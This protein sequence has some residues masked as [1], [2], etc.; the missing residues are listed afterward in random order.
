ML[1][2][3]DSFPA[4]FLVCRAV[5]GVAVGTFS[6]LVPLLRINLCTSFSPGNLARRNCRNDRDNSADLCIYD[7]IYHVDNIRPDGGRSARPAALRVYDEY[8][9][10]SDVRASGGVRGCAVLPPDQ[11]LHLR[12]S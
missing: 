5:Q 12:E 3:G 2:I 1:G 9:A 7:R 8:P 11:G 10:E 6:T 4:V